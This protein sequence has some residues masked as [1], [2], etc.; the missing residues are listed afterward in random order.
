MK[1]L[2]LTKTPAGGAGVAAR[3]TVT[4]LG[5]EGIEA[6]LWTEGAVP[7]LEPG[8]GIRRWLLD[9]LDSLPTRRYR[10]RRFAAWS[11]NWRRTKLAPAINASGADVVH[12]HWIGQ[13]FLSLDELADL[14]APLVWTM[15]DGW[16]FTGGCHYPGSC[17]RYEQGCGACPQLRSRRA[18]DLSAGNA[19]AKRRAA[20]RIRR[21]IA[22]SAWLAGLAVR[23][24]FVP[25]ERVRVIANALDVDRWSVPARAEARRALGLRPEALVLVAGSMNL[26]EPRK[27]CDLLPAA[28]DAITAA[29]DR[30]VV[31]L[32]FGS[33]RVPVTRRAGWEAR[34]LGR[35]TRENELA[36]A[37]A[38]SD[39]ALMPSLQDNLPWFVIE[40]HASGCPV[41]GFDSGGIRDLVRPGKT[42]VLAAEPTPAALARA[43]AEWRAAGREPGEVASAC[44]A[45]IRQRC[46][47]GAHARAL[48]AEYDQVVAEA[49]RASR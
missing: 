11:N 5:E 40:A 34:W 31:A 10:R 3:R 41:V 46:D 1:V 24:A 29:A 8:P 12:L 49:A 13:G 21:W 16:P 37:Y 4:A 7:G 6:F 25:R 19:R 35:I 33:G 48:R 28:L 26:R 47:P 39:V 44:R 27:G 14:R 45:I 2:H 38:A 15:H 36:R 42:G 22:P 17:T 18:D 23:S 9:R 20:G 43:V 30:P 32:F